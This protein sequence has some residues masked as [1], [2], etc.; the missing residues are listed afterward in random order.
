MLAVCFA[1]WRNGACNASKQA[2]LLRIGELAKPGNLFP[3][4][5]AYYYGTLTAVA[6]SVTKR[7]DLGVEAFASASALFPSTGRSQARPHVDLLAW[8]EYWDDGK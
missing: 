1:N 2:R 7:N 3:F 8:E 5:L 6:Q 4:F